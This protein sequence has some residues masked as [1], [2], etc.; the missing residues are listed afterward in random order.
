MC[1]ELNGVTRIYRANKDVLALDGVSLMV[2]EGEWL[3]VMGPSGSGKSTLVNLIG[4]LDKP[5]RGE[6]SITGVNVSKISDAALNRFR[7]ETIGF[8]FQQ[9]HAVPYLSA[10]ENVMLAQY[11]HSTTD[12]H[13]AL[14]A[15]ERVGLKHCSGQLPSQLSG[16][17]QQRM[18]IARALINDPK[19]ILADEPT[20]NL[21]E[22]NE[23]I[24]LDHLRELHAQGRTI[25][26]VT[27]D[28]EVARLADRRLD[29]HHGKI[30]SQQSFVPS[31]EAHVDEFLEQLWIMAEDISPVQPE[32][33]R[34]STA[35]IAQLR[36]KC[37]QDLGLVDVLDPK[38]GSTVKAGIAN[39]AHETFGSMHA[40]REFA[41]LFTEKGRTRAETNIRRHRLAERLFLHDASDKR[42]PS[43]QTCTFQH[44]L[45]LEI[46]DSICSLLGHP[47]FC[48]H[49]RPI[50]M[51]QCCIEER[52]AAPIPPIISTSAAN[53]STERY[54]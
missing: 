18:C 3:A 32:F 40:G 22:R 53:D 5:T 7:A 48:L 21:D 1:I 17:E 37:M 50:P 49:H 45:S 47:R 11:F 20:G 44:P 25:I 51:G 24:V 10:L 9:F 33:L 23:Q 6:V 27:H 36:V 30:A 42:G 52:A 15:L 16:G 2:P 41:V 31:C 35:R 4:C 54:A 13:Q 19:I 8:I 12:K 43:S 28:P 29:I 14:D 26:M 34:I 38:T 46:T 39:Q